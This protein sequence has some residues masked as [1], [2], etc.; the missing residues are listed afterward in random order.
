M[1]DFATDAPSTEITDLSPL[2]A[3]SAEFRPTDAVTEP[4]ADEKPMSL[5]DAMKKAVEETKEPA[6]EEKAAKAE[7]KA[8]PA[9]ERGENGKFAPKAKAEPVAV[10]GAG[11]SLEGRADKVDGD[12]EREQARDRPSEGRDP[13]RPP[14]Q[15]LP[16]AKEKW[17][18]VDPDIQGEVHRMRENYEKGI[19][20]AREDREFRKSVRQYEEMATQAGTTLAGA[21]ENYVRI[22]R[23]L[24]T[25]PEN[26]LK[27]ILASINMT[28]E[29]YA[30]HVMGQVQQR[31]Q[32][33]QA[34]A[35]SQQ[36]Q[37]L[38]Q[39]IQALKSQL[40][41]VTQMTQEQQEQARLEAVTQNVIAPFIE[42]HPRYHELEGDIAFF[43][44][45]GKI[46]SNLS[47]RERLEAAYDMAER[48][49]PAGHASTEQLTAAQNA[50]RPKNPAGSKSVKGSPSYGASVPTRTTKLS[51]EESIRRAV[52]ETRL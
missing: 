50:Q 4:V 11:E 26:A 12:A 45:S 19:E 24:R 7:A 15:F 5:D 2:A 23:E 20:A 16:R 49:N 6:K 38:Q 3:G 41:Q 47:E 34:Y 43:L 42:E 10:E 35:Q 51:L 1:T 29:S 9:P 21:L 8:K 48:I 22:D 31:Q 52:G 18:T 25:N 36:T 27:S 44:N 40:Q 17:A 32:N 13:T 14:A 30:Q 28:P 46:P 37:S 39:E 33:P